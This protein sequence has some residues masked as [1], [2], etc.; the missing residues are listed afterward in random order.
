MRR[1]EVGL[2]IATLLLVAGCGG[3]RPEPNSPRPDPRVITRDQMLER[4]FLTAMDAVQSL[5]SNWIAP[6]GPDSFIIP[7]QLWVYFDNVRLGNATSLRTIN[8][9]DL[10]YLQYFNGIEATSRWGVGHGAG[11]IQAVS[12]PGGEPWDPDPAEPVAVDTTDHTF[13]ATAPG[14][15]ALSSAGHS[16]PLVASSGD[17]AGVLRAARDL[18]HDI[19]AVT[20]AAPELVSDS[21]P[22]AREIVL[23]GTLGR[24]PLVDGLVRAGKLDVSGVTG[25]WETFVRAVVTNP[26][27]GVERALVI[28]GS[29]KRGTIYGIYDLSAKIGVSPWYWWADVPIR[30]QRELFV[31]PERFTL[32]EPAVRYRGIFINDEAPAFSGWTREKFGGVNHLAYEKVFELLLRLKGN[33][34]WPAMWGNAFADD[35][36]LSPRLAE[37]Y[38]VVMGTSHHEPMTRAQQE[39]KRYGKGPWNYEKNDSTLRAFWRAGIERMGT[40]ENIVTLGMRGD[41]DMPMTEGSNIALLERIVADQRTIL[42]DVTKRDASKTPQLWALYKEV[43]D[44]YDK[45]MR[46][47]DDVTLLFADDNWGN[48]RRLPARADTARPGGFGVYYHFDYVGGPRNYKWI[49]TNQVSRVWEQMHLAAEY[50]ANRIWIV[51]VGDLKP[52]E[53]P[54]SF[55]LDYAWN[56]KRW[57][58]DRLPEYTRSW[59]AQQ[60]GTA[61]A[62]EV[63]DIVDVTTRLLSRKKPELLA[64]DTYSLANYHEADSVLAQWDGL[65][66]RTARLASALPPEHHDAFFQ[67]VRHPVEAGANLHELYVTVARNRLYAAQGRAAANDLAS[68]AESLFARDSAITRYYN[69]ELAHGKWSHMMDQTHIGYTYWQEPPSNSMP[70]VERVSLP[71]RAEMG[72]AVEGE[73][74]SAAEP[75]H[76]LPAFDRMG[77]QRYTVDIYNRGSVPF[78]FGVKASQPW[79]IVNPTSGTVATQQQLT[80]GIDWNRAPRGQQRASLAITGPDGARSDVQIMASNVEPPNARRFTGFLESGG[81]VSMEAEHFTSA[82]GQG[83]VTW[84]RIPGVGRTISG[85]TPTPVTASAQTPG[86]AGAHLEYGIF[87]YDSGTVTVKATLSPVLAFT[88]AREGLRYAVSLDDEAPQL[89]HVGA[90]PSTREWER[91]VADA[92]TLGQTRHELR[93]PGS[94]TLKFWMIDPGIVL[95]KLVVDA[96]GAKQSYLGPPESPLISDGSNPTVSNTP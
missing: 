58:A 65:L 42:T 23:V 29:D 74:A 2:I 19:G 36:S 17:H 32:G 1:S 50:G 88:G 26:F 39:W 12:W 72:V 91:A 38:G 78:T 68:R 45:G 14:R 59:A 96:G 61:H 7:S 20:S 35:D 46:V 60:F 15:F 16:A 81:V 11:V 53:L 69:T 70:K 52:M 77:H 62:R 93:R 22:R 3:T 63:A 84:Q 82:V 80:V 67:L 6:R 44:Y 66:A 34:L 86:G 76:T 24:S 47:P 8:T 54:I 90:D 4:H 75:T 57:P 5:K 37:E 83:S 94:H 10:S 87:T 31:A 13:D 48:I 95:Q 30:T 56:P 33:Y 71:A 49:N 64:P 73:T 55:F 21:A 41:G 43:Q 79:L 9:R 25:K 89:V 40:R 92:Q 28:A 51:N 85:M 18:Q 27:P